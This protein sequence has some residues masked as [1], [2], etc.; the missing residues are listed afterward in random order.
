MFSSIGQIPLSVPKFGFGKT[1]A[2]G[3]VNIPSVTVHDVETIPDKKARRLKHLLKLNHANFSIL[4]NK[5]RFHNHTPHH[6]GSAYLLDCPIDHLDE[7]YEDAAHHEGH[8]P[9]EDSPSEI[10]LHDYRD[11]LGKREYQRAFVDF[12][13]DQL[14]LMGYD[15]KA[16]VKRFLFESGSKK[17]PNPSPMFNCLTAGLAHPLIHL[18]YAVELNSQT[19]AM[20]ALGLAA[21]CYSPALASY[22]DHPSTNTNATANPLA[23][24]TSQPLEILARLSSDERLSH[25]F[26]TPG[27][28]NL[29][30]I[31][32]TPHLESILLEHWNA[33]KITDPTAQFQQSQ[34]AAVALLISTAPS[35]A[36][37]GYDFFLV[38]LLTSS[39]A[40]RI[41]LPAIDA[42]HHVGLVREWFLITLAIYIA[43]LRPSVTLEPIRKTELNGQGWKWC[44]TQALEGKHKLDAHFVKAVRAMKAA[45][46]VWGDE[47]QFY[48][49]AAVKFVR[50]FERWG[51]FS[52]EEM[53]LE[54]GMRS[55]SPM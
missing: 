14:V 26:D 39:H 37:H 43:Q 16:V 8:D 38:H 45:A 42:K 1:S 3:P 40:V 31:F 22:L 19:V 55:G 5:L 29:S 53:A 2:T 18:G 44:E 4:Y 10:A 33:W 51:G 23:Y 11:F 7:I 35:L 50:E 36:G 47:D 12:F 34:Q 48:E 24:S 6:L 46:A 30:N 54:G 41:L 52:S 25:I 27:G 21:T 49:K 9:W 13:E 28:D 32:S 20:E 15:W 17:S